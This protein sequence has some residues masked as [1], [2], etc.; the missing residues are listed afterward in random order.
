[1]LMWLGLADAD[2]YDDYEPYEEAPAP[3]LRRRR[4]GAARPWSP[5]RRR[6]RR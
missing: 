1:M 6:P 3:H 4:G 2:E 5:P